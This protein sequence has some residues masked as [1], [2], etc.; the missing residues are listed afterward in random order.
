MPAKGY[1]DYGDDAGGYDDYDD[2]GDAGDGA[3]AA[4]GATESDNYGGA[5]ELGSEEA[6]QPSASAI[7]EVLGDEFADRVHELAKGWLLGLK[8]CYTLEAR[9]TEDNSWYDAKINAIDAGKHTFHVT[10]SAYGNSE[11]VGADRLRPG[12]SRPL[13]P[14]CPLRC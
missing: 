6:L 12:I 1:D 5:P 14:L 2:Y 13:P 4:G 11:S 8:K 3:Y 7:F 10:Y 9:F